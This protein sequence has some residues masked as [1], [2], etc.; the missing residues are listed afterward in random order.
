M[1][2]AMS[3]VM[4]PVINDDEPLSPRWANERKLSAVFKRHY[5]EPLQQDE[6]PINAISVEASL[7]PPPS[8][9]QPLKCLWCSEHFETPEN[10]VNSAHDALDK[11][12]A[13]AHPQITNLSSFDGVNDDVVDE[14]I[15]A[16]DEVNDNESTP[17]PKNSIFPTATTTDVDELTPEADSRIS[18]TILE[19]DATM[20]TQ[21]K[22][23]GISRQQAHAL[24]ERR[25]ASYWNIHDACK[26]SKDYDDEV[27]NLEQMWYHI[28]HTQSKAA[29]KNGA[30]NI[31][32][33]PNPYLD[34]K[35]EKGEF[36]KI[37]PVEDYMGSL[38]NFEAMSTD[39][40]H[41]VAANV[42]HALKA[43]QDEWIA[44]DELGKR[45]NGRTTKK[46]ANPRAPE[47][48]EVFRDKKE[49]QLYGYKYDPTI[50][51]PKKQDPKR[52]SL[53]RCQDP[54]TQG[55]FR[56]TAA[57]LRKMQ[58]EAG[59]QNPNPDGFKP[60]H[61]FGQEF[62]P[63]F[64]DPPA[65]PFDGGMSTNRKRKVPQS[66]VAALKQMSGN[67]SA[68]PAIE[69][70][71]E[72]R[73][74][75]RVTRSIAVKAI[76]SPQV[77]TAPPS[78]GPR[79]R[80]RGGRPARGRGGISRASYAIQ[81]NAHITSPG[82]SVDFQPGD[83][84]PKH[85]EASSTPSRANTMTPPFET[86]TP[87]QHLQAGGLGPAAIAPAPKPALAPATPGAPPAMAAL[88]PNLV[89]PGEVVD[90]DELNRR[91]LLAK[92]K[93]PR[94]TQ[95]MLDHWK[96]FNKEGRTRNPKRTKAQIEADRRAEA[97][98]KS[99][100]PPRD[101]PKPRK[102]KSASNMSTNGPVS[103][104]PRTNTSAVP[105]LSI[106]PAPIQPAVAPAQSTGPAS[107]TM[108]LPSFPP[109]AA[110]PTPQSPQR[111]HLSQPSQP[112]ASQPPLPGL[113]L[114]PV[115][116][117]F[118]RNMNHPS[119]NVPPSGYFPYSRGLGFPPPYQ[120]PPRLPHH[121]HEPA[122]PPEPVHLKPT[123]PYEPPRMPPH[124][125]NGPHI[126]QPQTERR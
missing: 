77:K 17:D 64:Q 94:R 40:L 63:R 60:M 12:L 96:R 68:T 8:E 11:H 118:D 71:I 14:A 16:D 102:R 6:K 18:E 30:N 115:H 37:T 75:K 49:A 106:H 76:D 123:Y 79:G 119:W 42:A 126:P 98:R 93:N 100:E 65:N 50:H 28:Y 86:P 124:T 4:S 20:A 41:T 2:P 27:A 125:Q 58:V 81:N 92:S 112:S 25:L 74:L 110:P 46:S 29:N 59:K 19:T 120:F 66:E 101:V 122:P 111:I 48:P 121:R 85:L 114:P 99:T 13:S 80:G 35:T 97:E 104:Q 26:F 55:G 5:S 3:P 45:A 73:R 89:Q 24:T 51:D 44:I 7:S 23:H 90:T 61:K 117:A 113:S 69:S 78:P 56:P 87:S 53:F 72:G 57:Q 95:A 36:L 88:P 21:S 52:D 15:E 34:S 1:S 105:T 62:V 109:S 10:G 9:N 82:T 70:D 107:S 47:A 54:F 39:E 38:R 108:N 22:L 67:D 43:W 32:P 31:P 103:K 91:K 84:I 116:S 33:R 83:I